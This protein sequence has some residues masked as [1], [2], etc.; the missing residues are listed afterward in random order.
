MEIYDAAV[1]GRGRDVG[2]AL[3]LGPQRHPPLMCSSLSG[4]G[5]RG[6]GLPFSPGLWFSLREERELAER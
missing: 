4:S 5:Q 2:K 6:P 1:Q 3:A